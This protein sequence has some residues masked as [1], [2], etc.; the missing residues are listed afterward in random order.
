MTRS[1]QPCSRPIVKGTE[2][3]RTPLPAVEA[4]KAGPEDNLSLINS[5]S[6]SLDTLYTKLDKLNFELVKRLTEIRS[7]SQKNKENEK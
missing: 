2:S 6:G 3:E 7:F 1:I 4:G 5:I